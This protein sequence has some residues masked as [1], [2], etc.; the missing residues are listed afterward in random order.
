MR[1]ALRRM[2]APRVPRTRDNEKVRDGGVAFLISGAPVRAFCLR[3]GAAFGWVALNS[4]LKRCALVLGL[5][6]ESVGLVP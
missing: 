1:R 4:A 2:A 5:G 3:R 6:V